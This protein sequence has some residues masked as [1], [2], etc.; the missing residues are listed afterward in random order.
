MGDGILGHCEGTSLEKPRRL[1]VQRGADEKRNRYRLFI[2]C[3]VWRLRVFTFTLSWWSKR[4]G[5]KQGSVNFSWKARWPVVQTSQ[6][7]WSP[8]QLLSPTILVGKQVQTLP[9][10]NS[11]FQQNFIYKRGGGLNLVCE[12]KFADRCVR[13]LRLEW[14]WRGLGGSLWEMRECVL[15]SDEGQHPAGAEG[16]ADSN[17]DAF[18]GCGPVCV[19]LRAS[20][21]SVLTSS[22]VSP[23]P[24]LRFWQITGVPPLRLWTLWG[25]GSYLTYFCN[26]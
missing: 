22:S 15:V 5:S 11:V 20:G 21:S 6:A 14:M 9:C 19:V 26:N 3:W 23:E 17:K 16:P 1:W 13:R 18:L 25:P 8:P 10:M 2:R 12:P 7:V 4:H 24:C